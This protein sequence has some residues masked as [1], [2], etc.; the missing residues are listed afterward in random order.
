[1]GAWPQTTWVERSHGAADELAPVVRGRRSDVVRSATSPYRS[2]AAVAAVAWVVAVVVAVVR[3]GA[4]GVRV[5]AVVAVGLVAAVA[6]HHD[7]RTRRIPNRLVLTA[8]AAVATATGAVAVIERDLAGALIDVGLGIVL[9][10]APLLL[11]TWIV[12]PA[13]IGGGDWKLLTVLGAA[14]GLLEPL[15]APLIV[16]VACVVA[17]AVALAQRQRVIAFAVPL[18]AGF[19]VAIV[20][21]ATWRDATGSSPAAVP[22]LVLGRAVEIEGAS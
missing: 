11:L 21:A 22:T 20:V 10:G 13:A 14:L 2:I 17:V 7:Q 19:L 5:I 4:D 16:V 6:G 15:A 9:S 3:G 1:M 8:G 18:L 12:A